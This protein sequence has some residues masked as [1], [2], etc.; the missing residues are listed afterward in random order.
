M[1]VNIK[2]EQLIELAKQAQELQDLDW[3]MVPISEEA[4]FDKLADA[5]I[6]GYANLDGQYR[7][8]ILITAILTLTVQ[9]F[10]LN[11]QKLELLNT[12]HSLQSS[13]R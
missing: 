8:V 3:G 12:V 6:T 13:K 5:V 10:V 4:V 2:K 9:T 1:T 11:Q 7:D